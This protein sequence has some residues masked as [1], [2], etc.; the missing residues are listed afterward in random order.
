MRQQYKNT[1]KRGQQRTQKPSTN[2]RVQVKAKYI[3]FKL[4]CLEF[5]PI[6]LLESNGVGCILA[7]K[8][9]HP[10]QNTQL[11]VRLSRLFMM[12]TL[13][14]AQSST[15]ARHGQLFALCYQELSWLVLLPV[16][17]H[18]LRLVPL[19]KNPHSDSACSRT[20]PPS[21]GG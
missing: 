16:T 7:R 19:G 9:F 1:G 18:W 15:Q 8:M 13:W 6:T 14:M 12:A 11:K 20:C 21:L 4:K 5:E 10:E 17:V 3:H 2:P